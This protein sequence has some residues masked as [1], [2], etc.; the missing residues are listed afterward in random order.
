M[1]ESR[2]MLPHHLYLTAADDDVRQLYVI[3]T[4]L[5]KTERCL[6]H[7]LACQRSGSAG[8]MQRNKALRNYLQRIPR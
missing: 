8:Q 5:P 7:T 3:I 2:P 4:Y 6:S 1:Y